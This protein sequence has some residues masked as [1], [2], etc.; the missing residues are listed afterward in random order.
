M[1]E[2]AQVMQRLDRMAEGQ[3]EVLR[4][5][6]TLTAQADD[7]DKSLAEVRATVYGVG[8]QGGL[9]GEAKARKIICERTH[10]KGPWSGFLRGV[11]QTVIAVALLAIISFALGL[12]RMHS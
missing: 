5:L 4:S 1:S 10:A 12:W 9:K 2:L 6:A 11:L 8:D 7:R 3:N